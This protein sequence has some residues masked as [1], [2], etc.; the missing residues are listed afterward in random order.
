V[1]G[2]PQGQLRPEDLG[3]GALFRL[4]QDAVVVFNLETARVVLL[5]AA[6]ERLFGYTSEEARGLPMDR[7]VPVEERPRLH[8]LIHRLAENASGQAEECRVVGASGTKRW[9]Q[10]RVHVI[11]NAPS[12]ALLVCQ[13]L[14]ERKIAEARSREEA[15]V[16]GML[17]TIDTL[18]Q[19][20]D[21]ELV[22]A[23]RQLELAL[24]ER[25]LPAPARALADRAREAVSGALAVLARLRRLKN[26]E[27]IE[28][29]LGPDEPTHSMPEPAAS[30]DADE[31][32]RQSSDPL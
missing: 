26:V 10:V 1:S 12:F 22:I 14:T 6:A 17:R 2:T 7:L 29:L 13:D 32:G 15:R 31:Q 25:H 5:N 3:L 8:A 4:T 30:P 24:A 21:R 11:E 27:Q 16:D 20:L 23:R 18:G 9:A 19:E 28:L